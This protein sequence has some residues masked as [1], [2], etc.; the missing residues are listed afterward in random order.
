MADV[1]TTVKHRGYF[2]EVEVMHAIHDWFEKNHL[3]LSKETYKKSGIT[4]KYKFSGERKY[5]DYLKWIISCY[6]VIYQ[7]EDVEIIKEGQKIKTNHGKFYAEIK[8][9]LV[10]DWQNRF[11][12]SKFLEKLGTFL[13]KYIFKYKIGDMWGDEVAI[14]VGELAD[15]IKAKLGSEVV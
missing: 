4:T 14:K 15:V 10:V 3:W 12:K 2:N 5:T 1:T 7:I 9:T 6:I 8:G 11:S 13:R